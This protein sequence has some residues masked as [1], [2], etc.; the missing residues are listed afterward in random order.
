MIWMFERK[1]LPLQHRN[2]DFVNMANKRTLW[3]ATLLSLIVL[4]LITACGKDDAEDIPLQI[5]DADV[6]SD[7]YQ[8]ANISPDDY[9]WWGNYN[10][11]DY[12]VATGYRKG[13]EFVYSWYL[14]RITNEITQYSG[15][16]QRTFEADLGYGEHASLELQMY[17]SNAR[18]IFDVDG[19]HV[20][21]LTAYYSGADANGRM[22]FGIRSRAYL[23]KPNN[24]FEN[25]TYSELQNMND[26][27]RIEK[28]FNN[29]IAISII[30]L[31]GT[32]IYSSQGKK[33]T[34]FPYSIYYL[35]DDQKSRIIE[36][37]DYAK[38]YDYSILNADGNNKYEIGIGFL[39]FKN[40]SYNNLYTA[41]QV[42]F[43]SPVPSDDNKTKYSTEIVESNA[44]YSLIRMTLTEYSGEKKSFQFKVDKGNCFAEVID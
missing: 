37:F 23:L 12:I 4:P 19:N 20:M 32:T 21:K 10:G 15:S 28:W 39:D 24:Q 17:N 38:A 13:T 1:S 2:Q 16:I 42:K 18:K 27:S 8:R 40:S 35:T 9:E 41:K 26:E 3:R 30:P 25:L 5:S 29:S 36:I 7:I 31:D 33:I 14:D 43:R 11:G 6:L 34:S 22:H 44:S